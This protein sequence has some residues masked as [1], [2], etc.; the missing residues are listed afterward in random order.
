MH[1]FL[2]GVIG[3]ALAE[4]VDL[5]V[6][7]TF[8]STPYIDEV[9]ALGYLVTLPSFEEGVPEDLLLCFRHLIVGRDSALLLGA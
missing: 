1:R 7:Y 6:R 9:L 2:I 4:H 8:G 5:D 3:S